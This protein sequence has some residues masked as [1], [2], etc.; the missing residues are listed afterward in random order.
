MIIIVVVGLFTAKLILSKFIEWRLRKAAESAITER[1]SK[2]LIG[3]E[4]K[5]NF[6][7]FLTDG[8]TVL[9]TKW[10]DVKEVE[11]LKEDSILVIKTIDGKEQRIDI[12]GYL[13]WINLVKAVPEYIKTNDVF[14]LFRN[15]YFSDLTC[16]NIC[17]KIAIKNEECLNCGSETYEKYRTF[18]FGGKIDTLSVESH[19][20]YI[21]KHQK[22]W[23]AIED[24]NEK[25]DFYPNEYLFETCK[26]W[27]PL[28]TEEEVIKYS[29]SD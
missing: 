9:T 11:L 5:D 16:C 14:D 22:F 27:K 19:D 1:K 23:F 25:V 17:G 10:Q 12:D 29:F 7:I 13:N 8:K 21:K 28:V 26:D 6:S 4:K 15:N 18:N 24:K 3:V 20:E 2:P